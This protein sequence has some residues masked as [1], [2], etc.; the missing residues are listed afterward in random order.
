MM[1]KSWI[2]SVAAAL[3][4]ASFLCVPA[5]GAEREVPEPPVPGIEVVPSGFKP[6]PWKT[7][8]TDQDV[9]RLN[10]ISLDLSLGPCMPFPGPA[11]SGQDAPSYDEVSA[12]GIL[13][14]WEARYNVT[15][16]VSV[17]LAG[18]ICK[19]G[20]G[21]F[22]PDP[23]DSIPDYE[24]SAMVVFGGFGG[25]RLE[26]PLNYKSSKFLRASRVV[27]PEGFS[28]FM[29]LLIGF[30]QN[31]GM[32]VWWP[33]PGGGW[34]NDSSYFEGTANFAWLGR[35]GLE[36]RWTHISLHLTFSFAD[37]GTPGPSGDPAWTDS[38]KASH[39]MVYAAQLGLGLHF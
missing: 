3:V 21:S 34:T 1:T 5:A 23:D 33:D 2:L 28:V 32:N 31:T 29:T 10:R 22:D 7:W 12:P 8:A 13:L 26:L 20:D 27:A 4:L 19:M 39:L 17:A 36:H 6:E 35:F 24:F 38:S 16:M 15:P 14:S 11:G 9:S 30:T 18:L 25:L 37:F